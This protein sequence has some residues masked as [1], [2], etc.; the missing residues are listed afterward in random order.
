VKNL[1]RSAYFDQSMN[2]PKRL[3]PGDTIGIVSTSSPTT[4]EAV[5]NMERYFA[6]RGYSVKVAPNA[7]AKFGFLAGTNKQR[8]NDF[9]LMLRDPDVRMIVTSGGGAGAVHLLPMIDYEALASN[10]KIVTGLSDPAILLNA[11]SRVAEVP[12]FHGPNGVEF[13][14]GPLT[15]FC[16]ENFWPMVSEN[17][18]IPYVFPVGDCM[19]ILREGEVVE[20]RLFGGHQR[21]I[22]PLIGSRYEPDWKDSVFF[23]EE[24]GGTLISQYGLISVDKVLAHFKLAGVFDSIRGLIVGS[25]VESY[26][27]DV[28]TLEDIV[29]RH[30]EGYDFPILTNVPV[31]HTDDKITVPIG[32]RVC[33]DT[34]K[35][36]FELLESPTC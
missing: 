14:E 6:K 17:L 9:N 28:E 36:S 18:R 20:G 30:C 8:A 34:K 13:G 1:S 7:L 29:L 11:I 26:E 2:A 25:P 3:Q 5:G 19:R 27:V 32:C 15:R 35:P 10:P 23:I 21:V 24:I 12:T 16:E 4:P 22:Q 31:G 33:L